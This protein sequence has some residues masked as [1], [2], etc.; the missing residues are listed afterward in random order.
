MK[1][2]NATGYAAKQI[3]R[4]WTFFA[5]V[6]IM[7]ASLGLFFLVVVPSCAYGF[8]CPGW[9][10][11]MNYPGDNACI[12]NL[13]GNV[14]CKSLNIFVSGTGTE[15]EMQQVSKMSGLVLPEHHQFY[16]Y[17][18]HTDCFRT[19]QINEVAV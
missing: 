17:M 6:A 1:D 7:V 2:N 10:K 16:G 19:Y 5:V 12:Y 13:D 3:N 15:E 14:N 4:G 8:S 9:I 18:M 11:C